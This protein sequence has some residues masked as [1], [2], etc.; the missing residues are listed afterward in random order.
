M[1]THPILAN[2]CDTLTS[3]YIN[4]TRLA[5][6]KANY[7]VKRITCTVDATKYSLNKLTISFSLDYLVNILP[8]TYSNLKAFELT[9]ERGKCSCT[10]VN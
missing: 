2:N 9:T 3:Q 10:I 6:D 1:I 4:W 8:Q 5:S 7:E